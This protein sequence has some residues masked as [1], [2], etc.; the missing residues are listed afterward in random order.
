MQAGKVEFTHPI[1]SHCKKPGD[2][3]EGHA[4]VGDFTKL[5][6]GDDLETGE[7]AAPHMGG[8]VMPYEEIWRELDDDLSNEAWILEGT[9]ETQKTFYGRV[10]GYF[11]AL[12]RHTQPNTEVYQYSAV[13]EDLQ[14]SEWHRK[15][16]V[17]DVSAI[18]TAGAISGVAGW[19][20]GKEV[21]L[22]NG[23]RYLVRA[24]SQ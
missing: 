14:D 18:L 13:R 7:M 20:V 23:E 12:Q 2:E 9:D 21:Q 10:G 24:L 19:H 15:Y 17:G 8:R 1:D 6:N 5:P 3:G 11:L 4:D 22:G 16:A